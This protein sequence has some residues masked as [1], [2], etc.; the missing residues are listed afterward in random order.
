[1]YPFREGDFAPRNGWYVAAFCGDIGEQLRPRRML[2]DTIQCGYHG[3]ACRPDGLCT[4]VP[5]QRTLPGVYRMPSYSLIA[6][7]AGI[8]LDGR[9]RRSVLCWT[10]AF[11]CHR[12]TE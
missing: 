5:S 1:M 12:E 2:G 8:H 11:F 6:G 10:R 7:R 9:P 3:I 4:A